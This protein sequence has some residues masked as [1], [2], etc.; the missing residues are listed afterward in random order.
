M[1]N[2]DSFTIG[3]SATEPGEAMV[4]K[5]ASSWRASRLSISNREEFGRLVRFLFFPLLRVTA[6]LP[7]MKRKVDIVWKSQRVLLDAKPAEDGRFRSREQLS[8]IHI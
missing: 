5:P 7:M 6:N 4:A 3:G 8:L 2:G 1:I